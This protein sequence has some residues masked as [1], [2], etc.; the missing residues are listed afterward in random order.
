MRTGAFDWVCSSHLIEHFVEPEGHVAESARVLGD[1][2]AAF[3]ITPNAPADFENPYHVY[4]FEPDDL[5]QM[6]GR[7]FEDVT[8]LGLDG[9][10]AVKADFERR[11][12]FA[13]K[14]LKLD[15]WGLRH[16]LPRSWF[17]GLHAFAR[18]VTYPFLNRKASEAPAHHRGAVLDHRDDR[19]DDPRPLRG[20]EAP[21]ALG[22]EVRRR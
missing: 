18:R 7:H 13:R 19:P 10:A 16:K 1:D 5:R 2:G 15:P 22:A 3:F 4:L 21:E 11:R 6:L 14:L 9:D 12:K 20:R 8:V 17:V